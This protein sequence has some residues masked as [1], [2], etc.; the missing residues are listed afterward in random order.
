ML[1]ALLVGVQY[2]QEV[3]TENE[4]EYHNVIHALYIVG[5]SEYLGRKLR[6]LKV[7]YVPKRGETLYMNLCRLKQKVEM[8][9]CKNMVYALECETCGVQYIWGDG[10]A[11]L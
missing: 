7:A 9:D 4:K 10:S 11:L 2:V 5:F 8:E 1:K 6:R 3:K